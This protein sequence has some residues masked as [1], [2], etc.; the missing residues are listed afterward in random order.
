[1][2]PQASDVDH[3]WPGVDKP[4]AQASQTIGLWRLAW[5]SL[6]LAEAFRTSVWQVIYH[7]HVQITLEEAAWFGLTSRALSPLPSLVGCKRAKRNLEASATF[8]QAQLD[9]CIHRVIYH[10]VFTVRGLA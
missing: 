1:M 2:P 8:S 10:A 5:T 6:G 7:V 3:A 9:A 4:C